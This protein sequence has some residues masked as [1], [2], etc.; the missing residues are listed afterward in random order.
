MLRQ[1]KNEKNNN[2]GHFSAVRLAVNR[3]VRRRLYHFSILNYQSCFNSNTLRSIYKFY[4]LI[5]LGH[6]RTYAK[7]ENF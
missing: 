5:L 6:Q 2:A 7:L 1:K 4:R 3:E